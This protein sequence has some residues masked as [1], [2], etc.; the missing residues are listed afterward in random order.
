LAEWAG[1]DWNILKLKVFDNEN[2]LKESMKSQR[3]IAA[4]LRW[5]RRHLKLSLPLIK[6]TT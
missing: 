6:N 4:I 5:I 2:R 3:P 1:S